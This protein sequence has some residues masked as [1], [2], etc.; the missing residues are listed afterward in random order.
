MSAYPSF[1]PG[2]VEAIAKMIGEGW[3]AEEA[4][5]LALYCF[6]KH[7]DIYA[8][9]VIRAANTNTNGDSDSIACIA[10][11]I[12]GAYLGVAA[13][14]GEWVRRVEKMEYLDTLAIRLVEK[15][16]FKV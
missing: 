6:L 11:G 8:D 15:K 9:T 1:D 5:A 14:S 13:I 7:P 16:E 12:S 10:G 3:I 4:V 2:T